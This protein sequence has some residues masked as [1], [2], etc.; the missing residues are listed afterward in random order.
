MYFVKRTR[1]KNVGEWNILRIYSSHIYYQGGNLCKSIHVPSLNY[2]NTTEGTLISVEGG[3]GAR[4]SSNESISSNVSN[5]CMSLRS[6]SPKIIPINRALI[7][8][9]FI[10]KQAKIELE[11]FV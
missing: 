2:E 11:R 6:I 7:T 10:G 3:G 8:V 1:R 9:S 4:K 5:D